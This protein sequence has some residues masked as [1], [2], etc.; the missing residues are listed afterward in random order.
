MHEKKLDTVL[1]TSSVFVQCVLPPITHCTLK[2]FGSHLKATL[3]LGF[4]GGVHKYKKCLCFY[5]IAVDAV[6]LT[7]QLLMAL[8]PCILQSTV[9]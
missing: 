3:K 5:E 4:A 8:P 9:D 1:P 2:P 7:L 6:Q